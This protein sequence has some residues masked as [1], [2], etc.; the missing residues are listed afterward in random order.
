MIC[1]IKNLGHLINQKAKRIYSDECNTECA[2][3]DSKATY[4]F[5]SK[6]YRGQCCILALA[7]LK[8]SGRINTYQMVLSR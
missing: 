1:P 5:E 2:W 7:Q 8:I 3:W 4:D 6:Q